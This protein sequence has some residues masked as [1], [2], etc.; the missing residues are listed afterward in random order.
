M[1]VTTISLPLTW[2]VTLGVLAA[3]CSGGGSKGAGKTLRS[4]AYSF[5]A[6]EVL[7]DQC[8]PDLAVFPP[9]G[10]ALQFQVVSGNSS[11]NGSITLTPPS[12][13]APILS[14]VAGTRAGN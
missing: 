14:A 5:T 10:I 9:V 7:S 12:S 4:G 11:G 3:A 8:W 1:R 6:G 2:V 13:I